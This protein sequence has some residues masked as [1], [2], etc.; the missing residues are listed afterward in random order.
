MEDHYPTGIVQMSAY[1]TSLMPLVMD[2]PARYYS[3]DGALNAAGEY[4]KGEKEGEW[5]EPQMVPGYGWTDGS[6][7]Y[8]NGAKD[9]IWNYVY[10]NSLKSANEFYQNGK[11]S[12][13]YHQ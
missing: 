11:K 9:G 5:Q 7:R 13:L 2:G 3:S 10:S 12:G 8:I 4:V 6:G 1:A